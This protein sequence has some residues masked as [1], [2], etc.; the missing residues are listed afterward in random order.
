LRAK[1]AIITPAKGSKHAT[2][3]SLRVAKDKEDN[4]E[5]K[6]FDAYLIDNYNGIN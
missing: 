6:A 4:K 5:I 3:A 1:E 2:T